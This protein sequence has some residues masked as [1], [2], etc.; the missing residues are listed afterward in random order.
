LA[1]PLQDSLANRA[2]GNGEIDW[3]LEAGFTKV[4][5][6]DFPLVSGFGR[7]QGAG[8]YASVY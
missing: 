6:M 1:G 2:F 3:E 7:R 4:A 8:R 5:G